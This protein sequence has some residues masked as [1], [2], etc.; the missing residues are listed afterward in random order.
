MDTN[1]SLSLHW[2]DPGIAMAIASYIC[3]GHDN[4]VRSFSSSSSSSGSILA[5]YLVDRS[6]N[7]N[8]VKTSVD[9]S[10]Q[11]VIVDALMYQS[12][13]LVVLVETIFIYISRGQL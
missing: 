10:P 6:L 1:I 2:H 9:F 8:S 11:Q 3:P 5:Q 7:S 4:N 12:I 13:R